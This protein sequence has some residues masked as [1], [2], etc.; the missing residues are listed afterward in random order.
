MDFG[1]PF[2]LLFFLFLVLTAALVITFTWN[3]VPGPSEEK[4]EKPLECAGSQMEDCVKGGC[5][6]TRQCVN[7]S[8]GRCVLETV[9]EPGKLYGC[10]GPGCSPGYRVC[11]SCGTGFGECVMPPGSPS[12]CNES[13]ETR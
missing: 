5:D 8:W 11:D 9:C 4:P 10:Q 12:S 13:C 1:K 6:G 3:P 7:G 2:A